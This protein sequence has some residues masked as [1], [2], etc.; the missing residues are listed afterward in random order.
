MRQ[1]MEQERRGRRRQKIRAEKITVEVDATEGEAAEKLAVVIGM[2]LEG[3]YN[4]IL[5]RSGGGSVTEV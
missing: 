5:P 2:E 1:R 3:G 4:K